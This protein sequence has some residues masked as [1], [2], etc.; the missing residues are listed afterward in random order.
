MY[1]YNAEYIQYIIEP[2]R[3]EQNRQTYFSEDE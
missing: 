2:N 1:E 3:I